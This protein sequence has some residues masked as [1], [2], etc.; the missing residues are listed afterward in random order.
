MRRCRLAV[1]QTM[2]R[3]WHEAVRYV[4]GPVR[5]A[6]GLVRYAMEPVR[7]ML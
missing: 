3:L 7:Y 4:M 1:V 6:M 5:Y 2:A